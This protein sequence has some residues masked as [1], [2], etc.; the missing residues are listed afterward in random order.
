MD[1]PDENETAID[2]EAFGYIRMIGG[3]FA[4]QGLP[5]S[6]AGELRRYESLVA[7]VAKSL[8]LHEHP[9][10]RRAPR[11]FDAMSELRLT[12]VQSGSVVP[13]L[14]RSEPS[15]LDGEILADVP[16]YLE[17]SRRLI[18]DAFRFAAAENP[19][20]P[21]AFP[22]ESLRD[23]AQ[24]GRSLGADERIEFSSSDESEPAVVNQAVRK[25]I[26]TIANLRE[27]EVERVLVGQITGL[28][29]SPQQ[30]D[31]TLADGSKF[32]GTYVESET[33]DALQRFQ[34]RAERA[35]LAALSVVAMLSQH[36]ELIRVLDVVSVD[37]ALPAKWAERVRVLGSLKRGW[38]NPDSPEVSKAALDGAEQLLFACVD[39]GFPKP[40]IFPTPE[41]GVVLEWS[42]EAVDIDVEFRENKAH[43][44][45][46]SLVGDDENETVLGWADVDSL[47]EALGVLRGSART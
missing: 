8:Y 1:R 3:R 4:A 14:A 35:P 42:L 12:A 16:D 27:L 10:R 44:R 2:D 13:V 46:V 45:S 47:I 18:N 20:V 30:F 38:L 22:P 37:Q 6:G 29:E 26:Q 40:G 43:V 32:T 31:L 9:H 36:G 17:R 5:L 11:G 7:K 39:E 21:P 34:G 15:N 33:Y 19:S 23:L 25:R 24:L 41:G 28:R